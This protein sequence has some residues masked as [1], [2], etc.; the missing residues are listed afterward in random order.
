MNYWQMNWVS[1]LSIAQLIYNI[2]INTITE[3]TLFFTNHEYN[4][5]LFLESKKVTVLTEQVKITVN[6]MQKLHKKLQTD[7][8]FLSHHSA[9][10]YN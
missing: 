5:N 7:I 8:K 6:E 4:V 9:F 10:Y 2:S 3:Q 1:L